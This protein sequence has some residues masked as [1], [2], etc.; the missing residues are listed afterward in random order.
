M[1]TRGQRPKGKV[2]IKWSSNFAYAIGLL[3]TDGCLSKNGRHITFTSKDLEQIKNFLKALNITDIKIGQS[4]SESSG[5]KI[6]YN[7]IQFGD[8]LFYK[9]LLEIG[10]TPA[11]SKTLQQVKIPQKYFFDYLRGCFDGDGYSYSYWDKRW[12][13]S[14]MVYIGFVS[15]SKIYTHWLQAQIFENLGIMGH[16]TSGKKKDYCY[17]LKYAKADSYEIFNKMYLN[18]NSLYLQRKKLKIT[19]AFAIVDK[20]K[21]IARVLKLVDRL[22]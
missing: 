20:Q 14:F 1:G 7:R 6:F 17:Q 5:K 13:S 3:V 12:K 4:F 16:I 10:L 11:K 15:A 19:R 8:V 18:K 2:K 9:F 21:N 22:D